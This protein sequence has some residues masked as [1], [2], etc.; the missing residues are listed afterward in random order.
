MAGRRERPNLAALGRAIRYLAR[1]RG[2]AALAYLSLLLSVAAQ[3]MVP[4]LV[5]W[6]VDAV[7]GAANGAA[8]DAERAI[9]PAGLLILLFA[10]ARGLFAFAQSYMS[11]R[12]S[13]GVAFDVRNELYAKIQRLSFSYHDRTQTGQL[14]IRATDDV[15]KVRTFIGQGLLIALQ[16]LLIVVAT[17]VVLALTNLGLTLVVVPILPLALGS[18]VLFGSLAQPMFMQV[19]IKLS[20]LNT[21]LQ[22]NLAG[23]RVVKAFAREPHEQARFEAAADDLM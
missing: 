23:I 14:M 17:L 18:F 5:Q 12:V 3:L 4:Q 2:L 9:V 13:Q 22:E 11:E 15:E 21:L 7:A 1:Y 10:L 20:R 16:A 8:P 6:I 19:Q